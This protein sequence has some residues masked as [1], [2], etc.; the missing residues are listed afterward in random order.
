MDSHTCDDTNNKIRYSLGIEEDQKNA[1]KA[2]ALFTL[3]EFTGI[4][5]LPVSKRAD[6]NYEDFGSRISLI[7]TATDCGEPAESAT[8]LVTVTIVN[9]N[10]N[11]CVFAESL[12]SI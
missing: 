1:A 8:A 6:V 3:D 5:K 9:L 10:D 2:L 4:V 12:Y 11:T 7:V